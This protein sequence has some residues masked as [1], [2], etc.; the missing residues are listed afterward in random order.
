MVEGTQ[1]FTGSVAQCFPVEKMKETLK[2]VKFP[3]HG[4]LILLGTGPMGALSNT[5]S[6]E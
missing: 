4:T 6:P 1:Y 5:P 3:G 2:G